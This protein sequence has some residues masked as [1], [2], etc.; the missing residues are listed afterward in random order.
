MGKKG[1]PL[2]SVVMP[3]FNAAN[4]IRR[5]VGSLMDQTC[6]D[7]ELVVCDDG[8]TDDTLNLLRILES[9]DSRIRVIS[10]QSNSGSA[11]KPRKCAVEASSGQWIV[12]LDADDTLSSDYLESA[13]RIIESS[14]VDLVISRM[15]T[16]DG[17]C[18][19]CSLPSSE[20]PL[21]PTSGRKL[22]KY[23]IDSWAIP[24]L[25]ICRRDVVLSAY[26][27]GDEG[28]SVFAD[29]LFSRRVLVHSQSVAFSPGRYAYRFNPDSVTNSVGVA[30]FSFLQ[31][32]RSLLEWI[33]SEFGTASEEYRLGC[34][35]LFGGVCGAFLL[36]RKVSSRTVRKECRDMIADAWRHPL[37]R[38]ARHQTHGILRSISFLGPIALQATLYVKDCKKG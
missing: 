31:S 34:R 19:T 36:L 11:F 24:L 16:M 33:R 20:V 12:E 3:A 13:R 7:W 5:A 17:D 30:R 29:E 21:E 32:D 1:F 25:L 38:E 22:V 26:E 35:R 10:R 8:S 18:V 15:E 23:T 27:E 9:E 37:F 2:F 4:T 28:S 6:S 14:D